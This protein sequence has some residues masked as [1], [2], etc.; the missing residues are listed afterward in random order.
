MKN[1]RPNREVVTSQA[2]IGLKT[3]LKFSKLGTV[4]YQFKE[5]NLLKD[6]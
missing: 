1:R 2:K 3:K 6:E 4:D 5:S